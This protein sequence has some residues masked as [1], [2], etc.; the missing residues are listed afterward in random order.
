MKLASEVE[1]A[2]S[3][4]S[5]LLFTAPVPA[6]IAEARELVAVCTSESV[7]SEPE[8][9]LAPVNLRV[10]A[11]QIAEAVSDTRVPN[12]VSVR[13]LNDQI[14]EGSEVNKLDEADKTA[15]LVLALI[16]AARE[17]VATVRLAST[18]SLTVLVETTDQSTTKL[19]STLTK[20]PLATVP[21]II[22]DGQ[23]P[24]GAF[25]AVV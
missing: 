20:S 16:T 7:A 17:D 21:Q 4:A 22:T 8:S 24:E 11:V 13:L 15:A 25:A 18:T 9:R 3:C 14:A 1:A 5:V 6:V 23:I 19:L 12:D 2:R 10:V